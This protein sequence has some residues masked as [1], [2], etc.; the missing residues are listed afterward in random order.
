MGSGSLRLLERAMS[1]FSKCYNVEN[2][3]VLLNVV[4]M[5][6]KKRSEFCCVRLV[7]ELKAFFFKT[8]Y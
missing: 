8:L 6:R 2:D 5:E 7:E 3:P 1:F 4:F